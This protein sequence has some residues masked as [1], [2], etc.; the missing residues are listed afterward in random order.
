MGGEDSFIASP[1]FTLVPIMGENMARRAGVGETESHPCNCLGARISASRVAG[2]ARASLHA[3]LLARP[4][5]GARNEGRRARVLYARL[6][7]RAGIFARTQEG[8]ARIH[9]LDARK[10]AVRA[11]LHARKKECRA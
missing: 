3:R 6:G 7:G 9:V 2:V 1:P 11:A 8:T 5:L 4:S 10:V